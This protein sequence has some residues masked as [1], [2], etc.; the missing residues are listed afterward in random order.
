MIR[1]NK[2]SNFRIYYFVN[3]GSAML[4]GMTMIMMFTTREYHYLALFLMSASATIIS[5][6]YTLRNRFEK[7]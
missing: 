3:I 1:E 7:Q 2:V 6:I 5:S 4:L